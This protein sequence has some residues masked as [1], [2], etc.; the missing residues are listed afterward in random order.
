MSGFKIEGSI[1]G[2]NYCLV[3]ENGQCARH[4]YAALTDDDVLNIFR[5]I[6]GENTEQHGSFLQCFAKTMIQADPMNLDLLMGTA[7]I[8]IDKYHLRSL[9]LRQAMDLGPEEQANAQR[10]QEV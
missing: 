2:S 5:E 9:L 7:K 3:D 1:I 10:K 4:K 8:L 6:A